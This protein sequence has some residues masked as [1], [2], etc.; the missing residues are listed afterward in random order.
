MTYNNR[1]VP[2][3]AIPESEK[4]LEW[5][6][7]NLRAITKTLGSGGKHNESINKDIANY[8][9][10]NGFINSKDYEYITEQYGVPYPAQMNK[11]P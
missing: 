6:K 7:D 2:R 1:S 4:T 9:L 5:C 10:Y 3:Q 8:N 11:F